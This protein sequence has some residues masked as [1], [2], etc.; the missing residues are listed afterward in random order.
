MRVIKMAQALRLRR[1]TPKQYL[2]L[3]GDGPLGQMVYIYEGV[4]LLACVNASKDGVHNSMLLEV[5]RFDSES[6]LVRDKEGL[7]ICLGVGWVRKNTR[8]GLCSTMVSAQGRTIP[9]DNS[10][11]DM[12]HPRASL[13]QLYT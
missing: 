7:T 1:D 8:S 3:Q 4:P 10:I 5:L 12:S 6:I 9:G 13:R 2:A 11:Y